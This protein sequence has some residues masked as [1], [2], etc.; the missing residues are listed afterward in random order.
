MSSKKK[1]KAL[2]VSI[3]GVVYGV[4]VPAAGHPFSAVVG[5]IPRKYMR[6]QVLGGSDTESWQWQLPDIQEG[7]A[8]TFR[9]IEAEEEDGVPPQFVRQI[10]AE[11]KTE[12]EREGKRLHE[13]AK[14]RMAAEKDARELKP[15]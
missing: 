11:E 6:A 9:M 3:D 2:E 7:Q 15:N 1:I 10:S 13:E 14:R 12:N 4:Y 5:N 8:I